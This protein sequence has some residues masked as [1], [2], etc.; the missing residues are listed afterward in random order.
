MERESEFGVLA[1]GVPVCGK[2]ELGKKS[3]GVWEG[4]TW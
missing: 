4:R 3:H 1:G 2:A